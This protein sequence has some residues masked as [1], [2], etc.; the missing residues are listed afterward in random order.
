LVFL[1]CHA[2][3]AGDGWLAVGHCIAMFSE[4]SL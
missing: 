2:I 3:A 1:A 4:T